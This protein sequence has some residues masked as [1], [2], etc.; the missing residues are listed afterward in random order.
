[1]VSRG[2]ADLSQKRTLVVQVDEYTVLFAFTIKQASIE[3]IIRHIYL[4]LKKEKHSNLKLRLD[5]PKNNRLEKN[6]NVQ[7]AFGSR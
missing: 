3:Q 1:M 6:N 5:Q 7:H 4:L 2:R